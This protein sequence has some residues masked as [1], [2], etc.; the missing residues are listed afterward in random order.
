MANTKNKTVNN[1]HK[2]YEEDFNNKVT[3]FGKVKNIFVDSDK[4]Q[5]FSLEVPRKTEKG[6]TAFTWLTC[7]NFDI[8][9]PIY[10]DEILVIK[11]YLTTNNYQ[12]NWTTEVVA[13]EIIKQ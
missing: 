6:N 10:N 3:L 1:W 9:N 12:N 8:D 5:K 13:S 4:V 2:K 11:G 7:I